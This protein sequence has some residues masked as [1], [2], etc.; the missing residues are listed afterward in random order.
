M[1]VFIAYEAD[2]DDY[3]L[4][5]I[6][7]SLEKANAYITMVNDAEKAGH[8]PSIRRSNFQEPQEYELDELSNLRPVFAARV[9][10]G[11]KEKPSVSIQYLPEIPE[12]V[13]DS[14]NGEIYAVVVWAST[15]QEARAKAIEERT[16]LQA[17]K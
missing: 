11:L 2:Y 6:F 4:H 5:G 13:F 14:E 1:K 9:Y 8:I 16:K 17:K 3:S 12:T 10:A 15:P 7:S